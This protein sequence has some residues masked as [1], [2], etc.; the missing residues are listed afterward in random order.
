M[1]AK[2]ALKIIA[3][4]P[5]AF[6]VLVLLLFGIGEAIGGDLSGLMHLVEVAFVVLVV[7]LC[8]KRPL[9]G[10]VLLLVGAAVEAFNV[11]RFFQNADA[12]AIVAPLVIIFLPLV[13]SGLLLLLVDWLERHPGPVAVQ[14]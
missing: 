13:F 1:Q 2:K 7:G 8:W 6:M 9:W 11:Y 4:V 5:L 3:L 10:G 12:S 14:K